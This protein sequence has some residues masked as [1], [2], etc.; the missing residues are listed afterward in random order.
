MYIHVDIL[1]CIH[2]TYH[3]SKYLYMKISLVFM[4][5]HDGMLDVIEHQ[6]DKPYFLAGCLRGSGPLERSTSLLSQQVF[7]HQQTK[8]LTCPQFEHM[9]LGFNHRTNSGIGH[10]EIILTGHSKSINAWA[11]NGCFVS[12]LHL[13][14][15]WYFSSK[16]G[17]PMSMFVELSSKV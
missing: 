12:H 9:W 5:N 7:M 10:G 15:P 11:K 14:N 6:Q 1:Y 4:S 8:T 13:S 2:I 3:I 16:W 17:L